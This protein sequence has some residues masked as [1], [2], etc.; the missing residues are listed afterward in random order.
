MVTAVMLVATFGGTENIRQQHVKVVLT[1]HLHI[2]SSHWMKVKE[3]K[4][5]YTSGSMHQQADPEAGQSAEL[6][7]ASVLQY[8]NEHFMPPARTHLILTNL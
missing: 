4:E 6:W 8:F 7:I 3:E 1:L 5:E 2:L